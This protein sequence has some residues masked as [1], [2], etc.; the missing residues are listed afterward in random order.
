MGKWFAHRQGGE[1]LVSP[2]GMQPAVACAV[3]VAGPAATAVKRVGGLKGDP[4]GG[5][6]L[7]RRLP[8]PRGREPFGL[9]SMQLSM[10][11]GVLCNTYPW[12]TLDYK[13][14]SKRPSKL[15]RASHSPAP[16]CLSPSK[17]VSI[18]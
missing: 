2:G 15:C 4:W 11:P 10:A 8:P 3:P 12:K 18:I 17:Y 9:A 6:L 16:T 5:L 1:L 7:Q 14:N 13:V